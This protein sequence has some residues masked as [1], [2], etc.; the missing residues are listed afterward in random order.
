MGTRAELS[1]CTVAVSLSAGTAAVNLIAETRLRTGAQQLSETAAET[2]PAA[3]L[4]PETQKPAEAAVDLAA[5]EAIAGAAADAF[6]GWHLLTS[7]LRLEFH[8]QSSH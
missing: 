6:G 5:V 1:A 8:P 7:G 4:I 2:L 3:G